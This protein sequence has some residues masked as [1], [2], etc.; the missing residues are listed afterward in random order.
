MTVQETSKKIFSTLSARRSPVRLLTGTRIQWGIAMSMNVLNEPISLQ[1]L[2]LTSL[3]SV[4]TVIATVQ[5]TSIVG[6]ILWTSYL[7]NALVTHLPIV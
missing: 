3:V 4:C 5:P 1:A 2:V 7:G 6:A